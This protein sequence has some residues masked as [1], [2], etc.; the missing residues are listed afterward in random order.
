ML[1]E[2]LLVGELDKNDELF[3]KKEEW[4]KDGLF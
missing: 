1:T 4:N 2:L 3:K